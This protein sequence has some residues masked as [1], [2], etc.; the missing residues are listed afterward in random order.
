MHYNFHIIKTIEGCIMDINSLKDTAK[1]GIKNFFQQRVGYT[2]A[3]AVVLGSVIGAAA[4]VDPVRTN[5]AAQQAFNDLGQASALVVKGT[6]AAMDTIEEYLPEKGKLS[7]PAHR[8]CPPM[9]IAAKPK[10]L[11]K[12]PF[13]R[14]KLVII[15]A[16]RCKGYSFPLPPRAV[17][18]S[19]RF[20]GI[21]SA[22][23]P[24][25]T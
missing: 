17:M 16:R 15:K 23:N 4:Y 7:S 6:H 19:F 25:S 9:P 14:S 11:L 18:T 12:H 10:P 1:Q 24:Q 21:P 22:L 2:D 20:C 5:E 3:A 13:N 8:K